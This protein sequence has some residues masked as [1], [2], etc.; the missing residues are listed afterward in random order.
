MRK[1]ISLF[2]FIAVLMSLPAASAEVYQGAVNEGSGS[3][4]GE[5][6]TWVVEGNTLYITGSGDMYDFGD[7]APWINYKTSLLRVVI[8]DGVTS[9]GAGAFEDYDN[10]T[11]VEFGNSIVQIGARAFFSCDGLTSIYLPSTFKKFGVN[12]FQSCKNLTEIHCT[13]Y[14]PRFDDGS[15]WNTTCS[16]F[17]STSNPWAAEYINQLETAFQGRIHFYA[18]GTMPTVSSQPQQA[19]PQ[20]TTPIV[21][22]APLDAPIVFTRPEPTVEVVAEA[23]TVEIVTTATVPPTTMATEPPTTAPVQTLPPPTDP[24]TTAPTETFPLATQPTTPAPQPKATDG[25]SI[26]GLLIVILTL[27]ILAAGTLMFQISNHRRKKHNRKYR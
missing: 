21:T 9:V 24:P 7:G 26:F 22:E 4:C 16:I 13:G 10:L 12:S 23:P 15:L 19:T 11:Q 20:E 2:L 5:G 27:L 1:F 18:E 25:S 6:L 8:S 3:P 14:F 17:Y